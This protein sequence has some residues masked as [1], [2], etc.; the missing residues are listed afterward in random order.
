MRVVHTPPTTLLGSAVREDRWG[1]LPDVHVEASGPTVRLP[2]PN[3][4][5]C[6]S[7]FSG[8]MGLDLGLEQ[9][10]FSVRMAADNMPAA[11]ETARKNRASL[12]VWDGDARELSATLIHKLT[13][14]Q[15]G[16]VGLLAGGPPCQSFSTAGK[17]LGL[18]DPGKGELVFEFIRLVDELRPQAFLM[19]NVKGILSAS[20]KWRQLPYN[21]NGKIID[22][23]H[24]SLFR[25]LWKRLEAIGYSIGYREINAADYG[26]PQTRKRVFL[27]GYREGTP[28]TFPEPTH[29]KEG[30]LFLQRWETIGKCLADLKDD[31]SHCASF[32][33]RKLK[34]LRMIPEGGNWRN[35]PVNLQQ[36]SMGRAF[37]AKGGRSG[38]WRRL[39]FD[40]PS[41]TILTEPQN[42]STSLCHPTEDRP[43]TVRECAR[44]QTFPD[45]WQFCGRGG[46]Q[47][48][49]V[50]NAVPVRL[51]AVL[52]SHIRQVL[53]AAPSSALSAA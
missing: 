46:D 38:Y 30:G 39:A 36:E 7:V 48:K 14:L 23:L 12:P 5:T 50:G 1:S 8:G 19:E 28:V 53:E 49:L 3:A 9:A 20:I 4:I 40:T 32:S 2:P 17:R 33:E 42:A 47:Y 16:E 25:E 43:L 11:V 35:L 29:A 13:G 18:D 44:I 34:Y 15:P 24:G 45:D 51:A 37:Y 27:I 52:G 6:V 22:E 26:V 41:P 21:N 10:G 31:A